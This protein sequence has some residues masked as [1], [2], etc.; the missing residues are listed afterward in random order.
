MASMMKKKDWSRGV[1][2][3]LGPTEIVAGLARLDGWKLSGE[4]PS[5][6]IEKTFNF[7]NYYETIAFVNALAFVAHTND[8]HPDLAVSY[9]RCTVRFNTHDVGGISA[10]D[11]ECAG[12]ADAL[13]S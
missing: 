10:T 1:R 3:A 4:G 5:V 13:L 11:M 7:A 8:H 6:A 2:R 12:A 9:N